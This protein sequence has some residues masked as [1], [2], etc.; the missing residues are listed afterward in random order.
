MT[1][2]RLVLVCALAMADAACGRPAL[3][4]EAELEFQTLPL[5]ALLGPKVTWADTDDVTAFSIRV[6]I[7]ALYLRTDDPWNVD[8]SLWA[9]DADLPHIQASESPTH[10]YG[11]FRIQASPQFRYDRARGV[12]SDF[13]WTD[14]GNMA[15]AL[16]AQG[17]T[18]VTVRRHTVKG[19]PMLVVEAAWSKGPPLRRVYVA[20]NVSSTVVLIQYVP[21]E[22]GSQWDQAAWA[23]FKKSLVGSSD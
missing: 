12:F 9:A 8:D 17:M 20:T 23:R 2:R 22:A 21:H 16:R 13:R 11:F 5:T 6:E 4:A 18:D 19:F 7:P 15:E 3:G 1:A 14:E 10:Q